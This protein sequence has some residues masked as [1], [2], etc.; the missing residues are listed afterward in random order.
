L[1]HQLQTIA[2]QP[3]PV[4]TTGVLRAAVQTYRGTGQLMARTA[5]RDGHFYRKPKTEQYRTELKFRFF[6]SSVSVFISENFGIRY[7]NRFSPYI[8]PKYKKK[9]NTKLYEFKILTI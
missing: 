7:R 2:I 6:V 1:A 4:A 5:A 3:L 9:Q 8:K